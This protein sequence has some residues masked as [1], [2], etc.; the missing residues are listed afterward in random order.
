MPEDD[1]S[2]NDDEDNDDGG[3][4]DNGDL[5]EAIY[6]FVGLPIGQV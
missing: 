2:D 5:D 1:D 4:D 6:S 3:G